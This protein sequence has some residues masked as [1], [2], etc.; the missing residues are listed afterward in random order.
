MLQVL[1][2]LK[3]GELSIEEIPAP[4]CRSGGVLVRTVSSLISA[5]T[6]RSSVS[7]AQSSLLDRAR[8]QPDQ[9]KQVFEMVKKDGL[10]NT[11][12]KVLNRLDSYKTLGY[13]SAGVVVESR[14]DEFA[15][16]DRVACA[17]AQFAHH[18]EYVS[19]P[20]NLVARIPEGVS[21]DDAAYTT[22]GAIALQGVRQADLRL[23]ESVVVIGLGLLGQ[24]TV[25]LLKASGCQVIGLD[26]N[27]SLFDRA[28]AYGCDATLKSG[29]E[30]LPTIAALTKGIGPDAVIITAST[31]SNE[32]IELSM[33]MLRK[34]G[35]IVIV[36]VTGMDLPRSP[37][38]E[39][40]I[41][42]RISCSYGPGRYDPLYEEGGVDYPA[43]FVR[44][45]E[46]RN[47]QAFL[48]CIGRGSVN[49]S[50][51]TTHRFSLTDAS[52]AYDL[53]TGK[54]AEPSL[55]IVLQYPE[56]AK[57]SDRSVVKS[58]AAQAQS[59]VGIGLIGAG[60]FAQSMLL[61]PLKAQGAVMISVSTSTPANAHSVAQR[62]GFAQATTDSEAVIQNPDVS[63]VVCASPHSSHARY[64]LKALE[65]GKAIFVEKPLCISPEELIQIDEAQRKHN[66]RIM[67]G[68]NRRFSASFVAMKKF[69]SPRRDPLTMLY[70]V[71]AG[72]IPKTHWIQAPDQGGRI[73]GEVCHFI[74]CMCYLSDALP[75]TVSAIASISSNAQS[76]NHDNVCITIGFSDGSSG[77]ILYTAAGDA[78]LPKEY[79]EAHCEQRSA[80]MDNFKT[81]H[82]YSGKKHRSQ[83]FDGSKGHAEEIK[84]TLDALRNG[85]PMP[86]AYEVIR[87][88][89]AATL[90]AEES[91]NV[92]EMMKIVP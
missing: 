23:G 55:G 60:S 32:P 85:A 22:V 29:A 74:D 70:R 3:S 68:F 39:K 26:V 69:L 53:I 11:V 38:Y 25:Q 75:T 66:G 28:R 9:V 80:V 43:G 42:V 27:E 50:S 36:G 71:N 84:A 58:A 21:F 7:S 90:A 59:R 6:E 46:N 8:K 33:K 72:F 78:S 57:A 54:S 88:I 92:Q 13:S 19:V 31:V 30:A 86:I 14:C 82:F 18:A 49:V 48:E 83:S 16:G 10:M 41:E 24:L 20:K 2:H 37:F 15:V 67:V 47:M 12:T 5:G 77:T 76:V 91:L 45:T 89:T 35:R 52:K 65:A 56:R 79:C 63:C 34:R 64:V 4:G 40:E 87:A 81:V 61:P 62:Y 73:V 44:W 17:G 1:Q 51:M